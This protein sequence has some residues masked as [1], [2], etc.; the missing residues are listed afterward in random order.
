[1]SNEHLPEGFVER[2]SKDAPGSMFYGVPV[3]DMTKDELVAGFMWA[4]HD[5]ALIRKQAADDR[6][7]LG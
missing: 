1:M 5:A 2:W 7:A 4:C 3:T 6:R